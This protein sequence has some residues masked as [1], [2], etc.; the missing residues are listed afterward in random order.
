MPVNPASSARTATMTAPRPAPKI[1]P[2]TRSV[3]PIPVTWT[4]PPA[5][6]PATPATTSTAASTA[7]NPR[8]DRMS[9]DSIQRPN[10]PAATSPNRKASQ[11]PAIHP[12][13]AI[14]SRTK[15]RNRLRTADRPIIASTARSAQAQS[16]QAID[17]R[18]PKEGASVAESPV[19]IQDTG[20]G[21]PGWS[22]PAGAASA[23]RRR[24]PGSGPGRRAPAPA[25]C[26]PGS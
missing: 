7:A 9:G 3:P 11:S 16:A 13:S 26:P 2:R 23:G 6:R 12:A 5:R 18:S 15:P 14:A 24:R 1:I 25:P 19:F 4:R 17:H 10:H 8:T 21:I 22:P 20:P